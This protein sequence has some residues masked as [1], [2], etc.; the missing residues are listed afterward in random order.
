M[1]PPGIGRHVGVAVL[2]DGE[3]VRPAVLDRVAEAMDR[4]HA[5]IAAPREHEAR[6]A[7]HA[8]QLV[9]E[10]VG[11]HADELQVFAALPD[12]FVSGSEWNQVGETF[13]R[14]RLAVAHVA[15]D[16]VRERHDLVRHG[17][18]TFWREIAMIDSVAFR[19]PCM[20]E[21]EFDG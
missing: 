1:R 19:L 6:R 10:D 8:D 9:V 17:G 21:E 3:R 5:G 14:N 18:T 4:A 7:S 2:L 15:S 13:H 16:R 11:R 12:H 20:C